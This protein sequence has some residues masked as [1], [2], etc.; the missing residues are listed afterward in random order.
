MVHQLNLRRTIWC[1]RR[2]KII[3]I[4]GNP[5]PPKE[6]WSNS[7][8]RLHYFFFQ[9][10]EFLRKCSVDTGT[11]VFVCYCNLDAAQSFGGSSLSR[12]SRSLVLVVTFTGRALHQRDKAPKWWHTR[13]PILQRSYPTAIYPDSVVVL[14][15]AQL[16]SFSFSASHTSVPPT[17][18]CCLA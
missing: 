1:C 9:R 16:I 8:I 6:I 12:G 5:L 10:C 7:R 3:C 17:H 18:G 11:I 2:T 4:K 13:P 14:S 15:S